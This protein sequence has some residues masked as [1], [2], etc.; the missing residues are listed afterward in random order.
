MEKRDVIQVPVGN[1][2]KICRRLKVGK[3]TVYNALNKSSHSDSAKQIRAL[4]LS[5]YGGVVIK[6]VYF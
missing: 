2:A 1:V 3:T 5:E 4:A 6:K